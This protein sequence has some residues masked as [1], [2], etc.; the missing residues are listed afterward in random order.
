M[1]KKN[2]NLSPVLSSSTNVETWTVKE[3]VEARNWNSHKKR[4][5]KIP[6]YQRNL[7]WSKKQQKELISSIKKWFPIWAMLLYKARNEDGIDIYHLI[8]WLQRSTTLKNYL[9]KPTSFLDDDNI[10]V[11]LFKDINESFS[12]YLPVE[13][14]EDKISIII[15][16]WFEKLSWFNIE[17]WY[18][19]RK[20]L[21]RLEQDLQVELKR[22][23]LDNLLDQITPYLS[24]I[25]EKSN[26]DFQQ[27]PILVYTGEI[28]NLPI[29]FEKLNHWG[30]QLSKY[31]VYA[32]TWS[33]PDHYIQIQNSSIVQ[34]IK[35]KYQSLEEKWLVLEK[36][37]E[38]SDKSQFN[39][40]EYFFGLGKYI[41]DEYDWFF[42]QSKNWDDTDSIG[43][44]LWTI[45]FI[46]DL[47]KMDWLPEH[48]KKNNIDI[49]EFTKA[50]E[51]AISITWKILNPYIWIKANSK[52]WKAV[53]SIYHTELQI[54]SIIAKV[55]NSKYNNKTFEV[56]S[57][58]KAK[59]LLLTKNIPYHY[60]HQIIKG[61]WSGT[62]DSKANELAKASNKTYEESI[63]KESWEGIFQSLK[64]SENSKKESMRV[65][66]SP[67]SILLFKYIYWKIVSQ[68][69]VLKHEFEIEHLCPVA[70]LKVVA[71]KMGPDNWLPI[72]AM[73]NL[74]LIEKEKNREKWSK[75]FY[76]FYDGLVE[77]NEKTRNQ[78]DDELWELEESRIFATR[79]D[80][81]FMNNF[82]LEKTQEYLDFVDRR[83][84]KIKELFY[85][86]NGIN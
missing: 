28:S 38:I 16:D 56:K 15:K 52:N 86:K 11:W 70:R 76:E 59:E 60:L 30:T 13:W 23:E 83:F 51:D 25:K 49:N 17:N 19:A 57:D 36:Q 10:P 71:W 48:V 1:I 64:E 29:I 54:V 3:L 47:K 55:F 34:K 41:S 82:N 33:L 65:N 21:Y 4:S 2:E 50:I 68:H 31:Q 26:I 37:D 8:D 58:W 45:C 27:I 81:G 43:F 62:G 42:S 39:Y 77:S 84:N 32:A 9:E 74:C 35:E 6:T 79:N 66:I 12:K 7:V 53:T 85:E 18:E 14:L 5:I 24:E 69:D 72:S 78:V 20:L 40:F 22:S 61:Y 67:T 80:L 73:G 46:E 75:T 63:S 44:N